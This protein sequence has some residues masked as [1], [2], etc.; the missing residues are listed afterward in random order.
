MS[1]EIVKMHCEMCNRG[2]KDGVSLYR[3]NAKGQ[4]A[5]WRCESHIPRDR[6]VDPV[7]A[8]TVAMIEKAQLPSNSIS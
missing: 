3:M 1:E 5:I 7:V 6:K 4:P 8:E 2:P